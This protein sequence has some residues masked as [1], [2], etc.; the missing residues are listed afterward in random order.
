MV[1]AAAAI[2]FVIALRTP[3]TWTVPDELVQAGLARSFASSGHFELR[4]V[5]FAAQTWGPLYLLTIAPAFRLFA[6]LPDAY[7]AVK[8][9]NCV[10][11]SCAAV[12][13]YF[14]SRRLLAPK[15]SLLVAGLAIALPSG[16]YTAQV[17]A[18]SMAY[19]V[20]LVAVLAVL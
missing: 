9:I 12:P 13:A 17:M 11:M 15:T 10:L 8:A 18:E 20:F 5:P 6:S 2:R 16:I 4:D 7:V 3:R 1:L 19:P 14:L